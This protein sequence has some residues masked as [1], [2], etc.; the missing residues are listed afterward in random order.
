MAMKQHYLQRV[1]QLADLPTDS[2]L[3]EIQGLTRMREAACLS[4]GM[5]YAKFV[6][7]HR[8]YKLIVPL[9]VMHL[10]DLTIA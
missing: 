4:N 2:R 10:A 5:K 1:F 3:A 6:P 7:V 8:H 9:L